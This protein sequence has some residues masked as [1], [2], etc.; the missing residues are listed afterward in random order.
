MLLSSQFSIISSRNQTFTSRNS[1]EVATNFESLQ[2]NYVPTDD[3]VF[4]DKLR[5]VEEERRYPL[6]PI[7]RFLFL[8]TRLRP[9]HISRP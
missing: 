4:A 9:S 8:P 2:S 3:H 1:G 7:C 6:F 5:R